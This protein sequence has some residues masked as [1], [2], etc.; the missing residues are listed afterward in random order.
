MNVEKKMKLSYQEVCDVGAASFFG[1]AFFGS[2]AL[3]KA[4]SQKKVPA[5]VPLEIP[6]VRRQDPSLVVLL[7]E[8]NRIFYKQEQVACDSI[9]LLAEHLIVIRLN[10]LGHSKKDCRDHAYCCYELYR[11]KRLLFSHHEMNSNT[12]EVW[13]KIDTHIQ[14]HLEAIMTINADV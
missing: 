9:C 1:G 7:G 13:K 2:L 3:L 12:K 14:S 11:K 8:I 10:E 4:F 6:H 5:D